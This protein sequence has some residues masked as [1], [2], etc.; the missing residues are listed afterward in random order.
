MVKQREIIEA[1][2]PGRLLKQSGETAVIRAEC[3]ARFEPVD[4]AGV[5]Q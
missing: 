2:L 5:R 1:E 4:E 3:S